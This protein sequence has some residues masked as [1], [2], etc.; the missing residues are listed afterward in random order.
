M[1]QPAAAAR[2]ADRIDVF[3]VGDDTKLWRRWWDGT[4]WVP[5]QEVTGAPLGVE[6]VA[7]DWVGARL[8]VYVRD[9]GGDLWYIALTA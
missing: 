4:Q 5:W 3:A 8:D 2:G 9:D 1:G 7:A 6:Q